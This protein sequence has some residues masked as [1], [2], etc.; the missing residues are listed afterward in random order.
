M[1]TVTEELNICCYQQPITV[2]TAECKTNYHCKVAI[3]NGA[4][5]RKRFHERGR[6]AHLGNRCRSWCYNTRHMTWKRA[7][8]N[9]TES[10]L[11]RGD[12]SRC[13]DGCVLISSPS[14]CM[15]V[16]SEKC[17]AKGVHQGAESGWISWDDHVGSVSV[18]GFQDPPIATSRPS[19]SRVQF[20]CLLATARSSYRDI[21]LG[22]FQGRR[23][24]LG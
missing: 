3:K 17:S 2:R 16:L 19:E 1:C 15:N 22:S 24:G 11:R 20:V 13:V 5:H 21:V 18:D 7:L 23:W 4:Y 14:S 6:V 8:W 10:Q 12:S 9:V